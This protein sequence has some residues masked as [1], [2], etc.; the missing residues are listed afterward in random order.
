M[1]FY[2]HPQSKNINNHLVIFERCQLGIRQSLGD[3]NKS[4]VR[5][6]AASSHRIFI[7]NR[8]ISTK[9]YH[10]RKPNSDP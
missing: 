3:E 9:R 2:H 4:G 1:R 5:Y 7:K 6:G 10:N 8:F